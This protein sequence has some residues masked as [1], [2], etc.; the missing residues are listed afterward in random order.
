M[1]IAFEKCPEVDKAVKFL[2]EELMPLYEEYWQKFGQAVYGKEFDITVQTVQDLILAWQGG[3]LA[4]FTVRDDSNKLTG[5]LMGVCFK[6]LVF[7]GNVFQIEKWY[8]PDP[9]A[10]EALFDEMNKVLPFMNIDEVWSLS[11]VVGTPKINGTLKNK[12]SLS[13]YLI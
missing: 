13:R 8:A 5:F 9:E 11:S 1:K 2:L 6:P 10:E 3:G 12:F 7:Q 4:I